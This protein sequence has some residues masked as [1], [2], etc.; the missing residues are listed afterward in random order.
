MGFAP[1]TFDL[2][3]GK[4][5]T[6]TVMNHGTKL[7]L[8][9]RP[10]HRWSAALWPVVLGSWSRSFGRLVHSLAADFLLAPLLQAPGDNELGRS[11]QA[12]TECKGCRVSR[13]WRIRSQRTL[14]QTGGKLKLGCHRPRCQDHTTYTKT[15]EKKKRPPPRNSAY[16]T[17][18]SGVCCPGSECVPVRFQTCSLI[19]LS[20]CAV[21]MG[22]LPRP[23]CCRNV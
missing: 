14:L 15:V 13:G 16:K 8:G 22:S 18:W 7:T 20:A 1:G 5:G 21:D 6:A 9:G 17:T 19:S 23:P 11:G 12:R 10:I 4:Q 2:A 3:K